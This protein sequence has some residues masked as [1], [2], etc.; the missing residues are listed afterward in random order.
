MRN[1]R[2]YTH[3]EAR[4]VLTYWVRRKK[5]N[6]T[7]FHR[8]LEL[9]GVTITRQYCTELLSGKLSVGPKFKAVFKEITGITLVDGLIESEKP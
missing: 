4:T 8:W 5:M 1:R 2:N 9:N 6:P 3:A 7:T